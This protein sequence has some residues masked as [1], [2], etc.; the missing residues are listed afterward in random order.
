M[1]SRTRYVSIRI[2]IAMSL[3][4]IAI[5]CGK[6]SP[7]EPVL[8]QLSEKNNDQALEGNRILWG[9]FEF[10]IDLQNSQV[11]IVPKR[12]SAAHLNALTFLEP[13]ALKWLAID[14]DTL[15]VDL[16]ENTV[17]V[18]VMIS[19]PLPDYP[20]YAGFDVR[21]IFITDGTEPV[22]LGD[23]DLI[24]AGTHQPRLDNADGY[25]RWWN[26]R[27]FDGPSFLGYRD[28]LIGQPDSKIGYNS[29]LNGYKYFADG[30]TP[31]QDVLQPLVLLFRGR[32]SP[33]STNTRHYKLS[34]GDSPSDFLVFNY[35]VD[36]SWEPPLN[37]PP[38]SLNDFPENANIMEPFHIQ[39]KET[40]NSLYYDPDLENCP[41]SGGVLRLQIDVASWHG[42]EGIGDVRVSSPDLGIAD[43]HPEEISSYS[44]HGAWVSV[45]V[46]ELIPNEDF[47]SDRPQ[48]IVSA[49]EPEGSYTTGPDGTQ[50]PFDGPTDAV[51]TTYAVF[52]TDV[53]TNSPP[54]VGPI[55]GFTEIYA[56]SA[57]QFEV[58]Y[59]D[60]QDLK[61]N[62][63][64]DWE[65]GDDDPPQYDDGHGEINGLFEFGNGIIYINYL[66]PGQ[67]VVDARVTDP[68]GKRGYS[69]ATL[70]VNVVAPSPPVLPE[71]INLELSLERTVY[72]S[73]E[74]Y[75]TSDDVPTIHLSWDGSFM[76]EPFEEW[77]IYR[78]S[79]PYDGIEN[80]IEIGT[81][82]PGVTE[83][84]NTLTGA[85]GFNS[86]KS[87]YF[88]VHA[89]GIKDVVETD[90]I[91]ST[92]WAFIEF[93]NCEASGPAAD[94]H[95][96]NMGYGGNSSAWFRQ[97][98][99]PGNGGWP[100]GGA[101]IMDPDSPYMA[102]HTWS[103]IASDPLPI[104]TDPDLAATTEEWYIEMMFGAQI[105]PANE[106]W[107]PYQKLSVGTTSDDPSDHNTASVYYEYDESPPWDFMEGEP[108]F[109]SYYSSNMNSKFDE[110]PA[111]AGDR[112]G[113]G[114]D[115]YGF[116]VSWSRFRLSGLNPAGKAN[117]RA[118]IGFGSGAYDDALA[119]PKA[120]GI[121]VIIY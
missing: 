17:D 74:Y 91:N 49:R 20:Q 35:A 12:D 61:E 119:R 86:G 36:A 110:T 114:Q 55:E 46:A 53:T 65:I 5:S 15:V 18:D 60:C 6:S 43:F 21:G 99:R 10:R 81:T 30:L 77:S 102:K 63:V 29:T 2:F 103:V 42:P 109:T 44:M 64:V 13:P 87:Y 34:F 112:Y 24:I 11:E 31:E 79:D 69:S 96:W 84:G 92:D 121:A 19:H 52:T 107:L 76:T 38:T 101:W 37:E 113:W 98:E 40:A 33:S 8:N 106:A 71:G 82:E 51:P 7:V 28:G 62:L 73:Y 120:D 9:M 94:Q 22:D 104:L 45:Y 68:Q 1:K 72:R 32:F 58:D 48:V 116:P 56:G 117:V 57:Y 67:Y 26:P 83:F 93:E 70:T 80:W 41:K 16:V 111:T 88:K 66:T 89:R 100:S 115:E 97:W 90:S 14:N 95:P 78:D 105:L 25:T 39:L 50:I 23:T 85:F 75:N 59:Y 118:A 3:L 108:Y 54:V 47:G 27:E 4:L